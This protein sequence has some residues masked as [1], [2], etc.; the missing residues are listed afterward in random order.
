MYWFWYFV[1]AANPAFLLLGITGI[2]GEE[3]R[4]AANDLAEIL[5]IVFLVILACVAVYFLL[6]FM[7]LV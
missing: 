2:L 3:A 7:G 4:E 5:G 1:F 6:K